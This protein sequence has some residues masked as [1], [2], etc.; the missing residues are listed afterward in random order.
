MRLF[1]LCC[2]HAEMHCFIVSC[3]I[4]IWIL[5]NLNWIDWISLLKKEEEENLSLLPYH[6][7]P[8]PP[9]SSLLFLLSPR[10]KTFSPARSFPLLAQPG[11]PFSLSTA[12]SGPPLPP[13]LSLPRG[14]HPSG[15]FSFLPSERD[16]NSRSPA[17]ARTAAPRS[18]P[19]CQ[20]ALL[21]CKDHR[22]VRP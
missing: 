20:G 18:W 15:G 7:W 3:P 5:L 16:S 21:H 17:Q 10:P 19:A 6:F 14:V 2:I 4:W 13:L 12:Q 22:G 1:C 11:G 9:P 8:N